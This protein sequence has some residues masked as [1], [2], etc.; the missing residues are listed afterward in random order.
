MRRLPSLRGLQA[1]DAVAR[2]G[3]LAGAAQ[4]LGITPSAVSHRIRGLE[5]ELGLDLLRRTPAGLRLTEAGRRYRAE[6]EGAFDRLA[7]A[8]D[9]LLGPAAARPLTISLTAEVGTRWLMPRFPRFVERHPEIETAILSSYRVADLAAGEADLALRHG[10]GDWPGLRAEPIL[11]FGVSPLCAPA[12]A[13]RL[14]G[15]GPAAALARSTLIRD[16]EAD[17]DDWDAWLAAAGA[18]SAAPARVLRFENYTMALAAAVAGQG[19]VLG[20]WGYVEAELAAG[21]LVQPFELVVPIDRGYH[22]V[23]LEQR[24]SDPRV[25]AFRDWVVEECG[26]GDGAAMAPG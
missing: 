10:T 11:R 7:R 19:L 2:A 13:A 14:A 26:E 6:V 8:T 1:F 22:L 24:L 15:L 4:R 23:Y 16:V 21:T 25:R 18:G 17:N 20:Y 9:E 5:Q 12:L 3:N